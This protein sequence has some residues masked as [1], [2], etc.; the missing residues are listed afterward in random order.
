[1]LKGFPG[2][3]AIIP[4]TKNENYVNTLCEEATYSNVRSMSTAVHGI[5]VWD[6]GVLARVCISNEVIPSVYQGGRS[7]SSAKGRMVVVDSA[8]DTALAKLV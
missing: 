5:I 8:V 3:A 6:G 1:M 2:C 4:C 7:K